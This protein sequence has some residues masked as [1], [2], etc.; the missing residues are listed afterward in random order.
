MEI[1]THLWYAT[2]YSLAYV[3]LI[4]PLVMIAVL[5]ILLLLTTFISS[6]IVLFNFNGGLK[7]SSMFNS[8]VLRP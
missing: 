7:E 1:A 8:C 3:Q 2:S 4:D 5:S 6:A